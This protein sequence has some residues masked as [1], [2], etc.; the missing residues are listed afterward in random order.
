MAPTELRFRACDAGSQETPNHPL[1]H[2][3]AA[4]LAIRPGNRSAMKKILIVDHHEVVRAG[5]ISILKPIEAIFGEASDASQA[6]Q[7]VRE[8]DWD[9]AV[10]DIALGGRSGL[11]LVKELKQLRHALPVLILST[12]SEEQYARRAFQ[13]GAAGYITKD[14]P[15]EELAKAVLKVIQ[16]GRYVSPFMAEKLVGRLEMASDLPPHHALSDRE[17]E[18]LRLIAAGKTVRQ[19]AIL[20][21]L[22]EKTVSTYRT[23]I[24]EKMGM[25]TSAEII[26]YAIQNKL[27]D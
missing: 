12:H 14:S 18:V 2:V 16:G 21:E 25:R 1:R 13:A 22:S 15:G 4:N 6:L 19:I 5:V 8:Q 10:L 7:M 26:R 24:L 3:Q 20:L 9:L 11:D 23:R 27:S 17:F